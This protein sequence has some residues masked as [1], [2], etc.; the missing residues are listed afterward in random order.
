[1]Y[2]IYIYIYTTL[3]TYAENKWIQLSAG[4]RKSTLVHAEITWPFY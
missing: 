1:M 3:C 4:D 2:M